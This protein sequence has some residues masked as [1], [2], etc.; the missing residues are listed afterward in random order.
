MNYTSPEVTHFTFSPS[1]LDVT[2][3]TAQPNHKEPESTIMPF[4]WK[5]MGTGILAKS[6]TAFCLP[7]HPPHPQ[8]KE[9]RSREMI[10][11]LEKDEHRNI[12]KQNK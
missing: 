10:M 11:M 1:L 5:G 8:S 7:F 12:P 2:S 6:L 9:E 4:S 3:Y